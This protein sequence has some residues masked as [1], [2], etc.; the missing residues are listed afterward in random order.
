MS[1][2]LGI[3]QALIVFMEPRDKIW[4]TCTK[5]LYVDSRENMTRN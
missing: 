5:A 1:K 2:N 3:L 4:V